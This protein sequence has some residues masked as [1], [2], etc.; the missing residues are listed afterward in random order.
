M[1]CIKSRSINEKAYVK[2]LERRGW[3]VSRENTKFTKTYLDGT[4]VAIEVLVPD[5]DYICIIV[6]EN[7]EA[8]VKAGEEL[9]PSLPNALYNVMWYIDRYDRDH[10]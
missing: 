1:V 7:G 5:D 6:C 3:Q 2:K 4:E 8:V 10:E 9:L